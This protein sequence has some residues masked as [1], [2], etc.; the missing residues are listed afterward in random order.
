MACEKIAKAY[1]F[2]YTDTSID[3][4]L[5]SHIALSKFIEGFL[6]SAPMKGYYGGHHKKLE[7]VIGY[8]RK[9]AEAVEKLAPAVDRD[10]TPCNAEYP[11]VDDKGSV[12]VPC[13][14]TY[15]NY[16][17]LLDPRSRNGS[18]FL[19]IVTRAIEDF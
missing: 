3:D 2:R 11:W 9:Y 6:K 4:L 16:D 12:V 15:P 13:E 8:A 5:T 18:E 10:S 14:Y 1:R 19:K 17:F 7:T